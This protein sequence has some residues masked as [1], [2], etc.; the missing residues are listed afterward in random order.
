MKIGALVKFNEDY[1]LKDRGIGV[2]IDV[3]KQPAGAKV[4]WSKS[5]SVSPW[6]YFTW[7]QELK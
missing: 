7:L 1:N 2:V 5:K 6:I 3:K 4:Y